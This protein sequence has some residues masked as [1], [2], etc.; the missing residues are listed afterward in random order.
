MFE[1]YKKAIAID[2]DPSIGMCLVEKRK[3]LKTHGNT[4]YVFI[5]NIYYY[6]IGSVYQLQPSSGDDTSGNDYVP[7]RPDTFDSDIEVDGNSGSSLFVLRR[8]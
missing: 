7:E 1:K 6:Y 2:L 8:L 5:Y 4:Y 3:K